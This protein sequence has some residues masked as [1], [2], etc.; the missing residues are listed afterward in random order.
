MLRSLA[1]QRFAYR[2][3]QGMESVKEGIINDLQML[4]S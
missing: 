1:A 3:I 2:W 4:R